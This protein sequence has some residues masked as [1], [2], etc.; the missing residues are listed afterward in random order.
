M[1]MS[2]QHMEFDESQRE[3]PDASYTGYE[4]VPPYNSY[5]T[6]PY[7]QKLTGNEIGRMPSTGQRLA[8][9]IVSLVLWIGLFLTIAAIMSAY[10]AYGS[11]SGPGGYA[12]SVTHLLFPFLIIG[13][14]IFS[15]I[16][17]LVN[18]LFNRRR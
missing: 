8:L 12:E 15:A 3:R 7:G 1:D 18:I 11:P 13:F 6:P 2:Q 10:A 14:L 5:S 16:V 17:A 9:A 4:A